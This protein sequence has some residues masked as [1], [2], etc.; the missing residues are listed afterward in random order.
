MITIN[1]ERKYVAYGIYEG[2]G[3]SEPILIEKTDGMFV[4]RVYEEDGLLVIS[5]IDDKDDP[6]SSTQL[7]KI[8]PA[9]FY[10]FIEMLNEAEKLLHQRKCHWHSG[11]CH[12]EFKC[13]S[14]DDN[15]RDVE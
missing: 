10:D 7:L 11:I 13:L 2:D 9:D 6:N 8:H 15:V 1:Q 4:S 14:C 5:H 12:N 3:L